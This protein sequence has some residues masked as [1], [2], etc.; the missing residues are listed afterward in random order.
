MAPTSVIPFQQFIPPT[1]P[2]AQGP[3]STAPA[4][5]FASTAAFDSDDRFHHHP[6]SLMDQHSHHHPH[7]QQQHHVATSPT[8]PR[9][10]YNDSAARLQHASATSSPI[11]SSSSTTNHRWDPSPSALDDVSRGAPGSSNAGSGNY[12]LPPIVSGGS[13]T[14]PRSVSSIATSGGPG[15]A[16]SEW[17]SAG[18]Q[19]AAAA[20]W[21]AY[22]PASGAFCVL[23]SCRHPVPL[24][25]L[26]H[27]KLTILI[28]FFWF[29]PS[30]VI[31]IYP[32]LFH[33]SQSVHPYFLC[34]LFCFNRCPRSAIPLMLSISLAPSHLLLSMVTHT[35]QFVSFPLSLL[36]HRQYQRVVCASRTAFAFFF[37]FGL[38]FLYT[39]MAPPSWRT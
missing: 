24:E 26:R 36:R 23:L 34:F 22:N 16:G 6:R 18:V 13:S 37:G 5:M 21:G 25:V 4:A 3:V 29:L 2:T 35:C 27:V 17:D 39:E 10:S 14:T 31:A 30:H 9:D 32:S 28:L 7:H 20:Q 12:T 19:Y 8:T 1:S 15:G 33:P 11:N 38:I